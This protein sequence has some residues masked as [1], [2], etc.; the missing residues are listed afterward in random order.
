MSLPRVILMRVEVKVVNEMQEQ[1]QGR[2]IKGARYTC[3][4]RFRYTYA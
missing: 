1:K 4:E 3:N 2:K